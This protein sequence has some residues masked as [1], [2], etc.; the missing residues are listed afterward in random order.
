MQHGQE[1]SKQKDVMYP[2]N[3][4]DKKEKKRNNKKEKEKKI[5]K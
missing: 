1:T 4:K 5:H 2:K 3:K